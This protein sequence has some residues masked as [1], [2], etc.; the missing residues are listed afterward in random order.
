MLPEVNLLPKI[1][2]TES[3]LYTVFLIGLILFLITLGIFIYFYISITNQLNATEQRVATLE[4]EKQILEANYNTHLA[5]ETGPSFSE[6]VAYIAE[7][8]LPTSRLV[9]EYITL[10]PDHAYLSN[11]NFDYTTVSI[12]TQ[13]E[14]IDDTSLYVANLTESELLDKVIIEQVSTFEVGDGGMS[15]EE[16]GVLYDTI[17]RY[18]VS[19]SMEVNQEKLAGEEEHNEPAISGE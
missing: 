8:R 18:D 13:F 17:P 6:A 14:T 5:D 10:L 16:A 15:E 7:H 19:Y 1:E 11:Y 9:D 2:R 3:R 12:Q 4:S